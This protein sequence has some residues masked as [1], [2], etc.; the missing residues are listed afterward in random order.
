LAARTAI[1][2][3]LHEA[4]ALEGGSPWFAMTRVTLPLMTPIILVLAVRDVVVVVQNAFVPALLLTDGGPANATL[5]A[6]LLIY[7]R[8]FEYG[9]LG[10][11]ATLSLT[12]LLLTTAAAALPLWLAARL[13][14][15]QRTRS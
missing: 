2:P 12:L 13:A 10:Y 4:I 3:T 8:A 11:A 15:R 7:R 6:P 5:T 1:P 14:A 9:E